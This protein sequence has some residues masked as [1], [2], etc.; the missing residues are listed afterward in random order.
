MGAEVEGGGWEARGRSSS[1]CCAHYLP[2][3]RRGSR[4]QSD[5]RAG[6]SSGGGVRTVDQQGADA[7]PLCQCDGVETV[8]RRFGIQMRWCGFQLSHDRVIWN[9]SCLN[10]MVDPA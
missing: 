4:R 6:P 7:S 10:A 5:K 1:S 9:C 3:D 2:S 8:M